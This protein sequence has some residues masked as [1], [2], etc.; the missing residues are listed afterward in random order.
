[1]SYVSK[2][3]WA[4]REKKV[5]ELLKTK[6]CAEAARELQVSEDTLRDWRRRFGMLKYTGQKKAKIPREELER[7]LQ[8]MTRH[9]IARANHMAFDTVNNM[10]REYG[11]TVPRLRKNQKGT[12]IDS[13]CFDCR[14]GACG[15]SW[16]MWFQPVKGW[17][18]IPHLRDNGYMT[19]TVLKCPQFIPDRRNEEE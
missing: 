2:A 8:T 1:M 4:E 17:E 16:S 18:A 19:Y 13:I 14:N 9:Q 10:I 6:T 3:E 5:R 7:M 15:C 12:K 11:L